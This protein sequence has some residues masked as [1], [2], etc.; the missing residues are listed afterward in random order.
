MAFAVMLVSVKLLS[1][2]VPAGEVVF[3]RS[4]LAVFPVLAMVWSQGQLSE[5]LKTSRPGGHVIRSVVGVT[6]MA[7]WFFGVQRLPLADGLADRKSTRLNSS[8]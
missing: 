3:F 7:L 4:A 8:H 5:G 1:G 2:R 6:A